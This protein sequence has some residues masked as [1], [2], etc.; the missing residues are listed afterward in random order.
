MLPCFAAAGRPGQA[1]SGRDRRRLR[2]LARRCRGAASATGSTGTGFKAKPGAVALLPT[3]GGWRSAPRRR[4]PG[5]ALGRRRPPGRPAAPAT[6]AWTTRDDLLPPDRAALGWALAAYR[7][8]RYRRDE[9]PAAAPR[10]CPKVRASPVPCHLAEATWQA[11]DLINTPA[12]D[13]GPARAGGRRSRGGRPIRR[14]LPGDRRRRAPRGQLP[15]R[16]RRR[17]RQR[18]G[19]RA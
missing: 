11:R 7:F 6:G 18:R 5:R 15:G 10:C 13:L 1:G 3:P 17:S 12:N 9:T 14:R 19:R 2:R 8:T 4:R 16:P